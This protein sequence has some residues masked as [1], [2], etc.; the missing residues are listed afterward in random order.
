[1]V[2]KANRSTNCLVKVQRG[3]IAFGAPLVLALTVKFIINL[4]FFRKIIPAK[5]LQG[6]KNLEGLGQNIFLSIAHVQRKPSK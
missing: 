6:F 3:F 2:S 5:N 1:M 4:W